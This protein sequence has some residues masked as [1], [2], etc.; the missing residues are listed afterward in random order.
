MTLITPLSTGSPLIFLDVP[1]GPKE[2]TAL[3][4]T[5]LIPLG[6][7]LLAGR[8]PG[9]VVLHNLYARGCLRFAAVPVVTVDTVTCFWFDRISLSEG[10]Q[11]LYN[12]AVSCYTNNITT[13]RWEHDSMGMFKMQIYLRSRNAPGQLPIMQRDLHL[14]R[15]HLLYT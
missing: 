12:I 1:A 4:F 3:T 11:I 14:Y 5:D 6:E 15:R 9:A 8:T 2:R 7:V 13:W 10:F